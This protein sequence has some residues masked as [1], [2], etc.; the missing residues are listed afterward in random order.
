MSDNIPVSSTMLP[1]HEA[2]N[3]FPLLTGADFDRLVASI[4]SLGQQEP[5]QLL[6]G[7]ILDGRN[8]YLACQKLG[9][10]P[11]TIE[12]GELPCS[13]LD[14]VLVKNLHRRHLT[15]SQRARSAARA[16]PW[17][18]K[19]A[20]ERRR[21]KTSDFVPAN[22]PGQHGGDARDVAA[23]AFG[24]S[25]RTVDYAAKVLAHGS[26]ELIRNVE[27]GTVAVSAAAKLAQ[28]PKA[29]QAAALGDGK[30][31]VRQAVVTGESAQT[32][33]SVGAQGQSTLHTSE[34]RDADHASQI[35]AAVNHLANLLQQLIRDDEACD[36]MQ[37]TFTVFR[38]AVANWYARWLAGGHPLLVERHFDEDPF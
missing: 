1:F 18:V 31:V 5:V 16:L 2:A 33:G 6:K 7:K 4:Q 36:T 15:P 38:D 27:Q 35:T 29:E 34:R 23:K 28:L 8:R 11:K 17:F 14:Y 9:I 24:V 13:P 37:N 3:I 30:A 10:N 21:R 26:D 20:E 22:L 19:E 25:G 32:V 12:I